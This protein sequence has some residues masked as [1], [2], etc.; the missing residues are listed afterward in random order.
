MLAK[1]WK[2]T[3]L[4]WEAWRK[5]PR[6][7]AWKSSNA[8]ALDFS[9]SVDNVVAAVAMS[10]KLWVVCTGVFIGIV[11]MRLIAGWCLGLIQRFPILDEAAFLLI[12]YV[13]VLLIAELVAHLEFTS[14][15][16]FLG[17]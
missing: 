12:G 6:A 15:A 4:N 13:A 2:W 3:R 16:K 5:A 1:R 17:V 11:T 8:V 9:L 14:G 10:P 7:G